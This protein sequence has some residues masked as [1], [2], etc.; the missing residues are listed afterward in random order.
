MVV[1]AGGVASQ[2]LVKVLA[3]LVHGQRQVPVVDKALHLRVGEQLRGRH[4]VELQ[5]DPLD[6][7]VR[8]SKYDQL[9]T[10]PAPA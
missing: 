6:G 8:P 4:V 2:R 9:R 1:K 3:E 10:P 5:Y 7:Q